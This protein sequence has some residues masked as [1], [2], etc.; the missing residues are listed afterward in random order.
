MKTK[1]WMTGWIA[2]LLLCTFLLPAQAVEA[3][4]KPQE[5]T[6]T[7]TYQNADYRG[8]SAIETAEKKLA[9]LALSSEMIRQLSA[10]KNGVDSKRNADHGEI[11][12]LCGILFVS[13]PNG[14]SG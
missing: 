2:I 11:Y 8:L 13:R 5:S 9:S 12:L 3:G 14:Y 10:D 4:G 1:R 6:E 7:V